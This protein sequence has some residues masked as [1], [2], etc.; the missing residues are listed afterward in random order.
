MEESTTLQITMP[1]LGLPAKSK[2]TLKEWETL[3]R[4][5]PGQGDEVILGRRRDEPLPKSVAEVR[6]KAAR[7]SFHNLDPFV[8]TVA[9]GIASGQAE[10]P[11][12]ETTLKISLPEFYDKELELPLST[13]NGPGAPML[14]ILPGIYGGGDS[15]H[16]HLLKKLALERG[17]NYVVFPNSL[18]D[19]MLKNAPHDHPGNPRL[20]ALSSHR[21][22]GSLKEQY[23]ELFGQ[24]S[25]AGYSYG[26]LHGANLVRL[27]EEGSKRLINGSLVAVSPPQNL[28]HSMRQ[29][30]GLRDYYREGSDSISEVGLR[31]K[32]DV[33]K[34]GYARFME[35]KLCEHGPGTNITEIEMS[36]KYGSRDNL[37]EMIETVDV[38][39]G[40]NQLP[41]NTQAYQDAGFVEKIRMRR[42]H[43]KIVENMTYDQFSSEWMS[44]DHW[45]VEHHLSPSV[46]A[47]KYSFPEAMQAI[48][49]TPVL[50]FASSDDYILN[51]TDV[52]ALRKLEQRPGELEVVKLFPTGGH[53]GI[54]WNPEIAETMI[55][56]A[57]A[58]K[59]PAKG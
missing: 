19:T 46:M 14:L 33:K 44:K 38:Q 59:I 41:K 57:A 4:P 48:T 55:D 5:E 58:G 45:L 11:K 22:L 29:L 2:P 36:D 34:Y 39:F 12:G 42:E 47:A 49:R 56:F 10:L 37:K 28:E 26:A 30:D 13:Q 15:G 17:M 43:D 20:D 23:P 27:D 18:S 31:Y 24:I 32:H 21:L 16:S 8:A 1:S 51:A 50:V 54:D 40:H 9:G 25:V 7:L 35:S 53:V 3:I 52:T 6:Q